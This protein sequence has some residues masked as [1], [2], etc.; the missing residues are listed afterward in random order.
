[1]KSAQSHLELFKARKMEIRTKE[2]KA[3]VEKFM[4]EKGAEAKSEISR[5]AM[6]EIL[7]ENNRRI[8]RERQ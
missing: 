6:K 5:V 7:I 2:Y 1:M 4:T 8:Q 3:K